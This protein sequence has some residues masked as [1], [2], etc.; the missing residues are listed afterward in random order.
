M[1]IEMNDILQMVRSGQLAEATGAIQRRLG[2]GR[3]A[4]PPMRGRDAPGEGPAR[5]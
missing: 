4:E 2:S 3:E 5:A 1:S